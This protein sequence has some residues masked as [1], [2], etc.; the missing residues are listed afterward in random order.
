MKIITFLF[1]ILF[2][3]TLTFT[4]N[5]AEVK[6]GILDFQTNSASAYYQSFSPVVANEIITDLLKIKGIKI[7][8]RQKLEAKTRHIIA[9]HKNKYT[10]KQLTRIQK[11]AK[12][13]DLVL[14]GTYSVKD[15]KIKFTIKFFE[16]KRKRIVNTFKISGVEEDL[17]NIV[18]QIV[19]RTI[20]VL[21]NKLS[22]SYNIKMT[23]KLKAQ[24]ELYNKTNYKAYKAYKEVSY[25]LSFRDYQRAIQACERTIR[26]D[27]DFLEPYETLGK[28]YEKLK[29][30]PQA[31]Y[32][33]NQFLTRNLSEL[34]QESLIDFYFKIAQY[35]DVEGEF[36][37]SLS[38]YQ[39]ALKYEKNF[40]DPYSLGEKLFY[41]GVEKYKTGDYEGAIK[42]LNESVAIYAKTGFEGSLARSH[43]GLGYIYFKM[44]DTK[45]AE[46]YFNQALKTFEKLGNLYEAAKIYN[47]LGLIYTQANDQEK[48]LTFF[49]MSQV[50]WQN[51]GSKQEMIKVYLNM[52][53]AEEKKG[54][55][56]NAI[57]YYKKALIESQ[58]IG[59]HTKI[60]FFHD[61]VSKLSLKE[62]GTLAPEIESF[63]LIA[64][65]DM[66]KNSGILFNN[67]GLLFQTQKKNDKA[68]EY[69]IKA[70]NINE[71]LNH[72]LLLEVSYN[73]IGV[74]YFQKEKYDYSFLYLVKAMKISEALGDKPRLAKHYH[75]IGAVYFKKKEYDKAALA[76][77]RS[78]QLREK[79]GDRLSIAS[80]CYNLAV[81]KI[82]TGKKDEAREYLEKAIDIEKSYG[83]PQYKASVELM[84]KL[85]N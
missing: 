32:Y 22:R 61:Y 85:A 67:L 79:I 47:M 66:L 50:F 76:F 74:I 46:Q 70:L 12:G 64:E 62:F 75:N 63:E 65:Y 21:K 15:R 28:I 59:D 10:K 81:L 30:Y 82:A 68:F 6:I 69:F 2:F 17:L 38:Y 78:L 34:N 42:D 45:K 54:N 14:L 29:K 83:G 26:M 11:A 40:N 24:I 31:F 3:I 19:F 25:Y 52:G 41:V 23:P 56:K 1:S 35:L 4:A 49:G 80:T 33:Y 53:L 18:D 77:K 44:K 57:E 73:N 7:F 9:Y 39:V 36:A 13:A 51:T 37:A 27:A 71:K 43:Q 60:L 58:L 16:P 48:A 72:K 5:A 8:D 55:N 20:D 84:K